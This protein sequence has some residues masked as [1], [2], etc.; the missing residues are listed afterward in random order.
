MT[1]SAQVLGVNPRQIWSF[2]TSNPDFILMSNLSQFAN[3]NR[4]R[5]YSTNT[6]YTSNWVDIAVGLAVGKIN[7]LLLCVTEITITEKK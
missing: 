6:Y 5:V 1:Y 2:S 3:K 7:L 4:Q